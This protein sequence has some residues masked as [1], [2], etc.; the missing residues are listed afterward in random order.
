MK[1]HIHS[2]KMDVIMSSVQ[3]HVKSPAFTCEFCNKSFMTE[4]NLMKHL[5]EYKRRWQDKSLP[6]NMMGFQIWQEFYVKN[7]VTLK[8]KTYLDFTKSAYYSVFVKFAN[9][10]I[11]INAINVMRFAHWLMENKVKID[12]WCKD[13]YYNT[14]LTQYLKDEDPLD[15]VARGIETMIEVAKQ[16]E[17]KSNDCL[18]YAN[19]NRVLHL[20]SNGKISP[21]I[22]YQSESGIGFLESLNDTQEKMIIEYINPEQ[23]AIKFKRCSTDVNKVKELLKEA[24]Y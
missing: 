14:F 6:G 21:W 9:Y 3:A 11:D 15:A 1:K 20:I 18:R 12:M 13:S 4:K 19:K 17:I 24:G 16:Y 2:I 10:C 8:K 22:L 23:W 5:C 7:T